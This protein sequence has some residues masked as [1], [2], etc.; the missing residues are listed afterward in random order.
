VLRPDACAIDVG[1]PLE[2]QADRT[3]LRPPE[4]LA[5]VEALAYP[6]AMA[7]DCA[8]RDDRLAK[9][10]RH[11]DRGELGGR[12]RDQRIAEVLQL[13]ALALELALARRIGFFV[14]VVRAHRAGC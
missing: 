12:Q 6:R 11:V 5:D 7:R 4:E 3:C 10:V 1:T 8:C 9:L 2:R 14:I 13:A